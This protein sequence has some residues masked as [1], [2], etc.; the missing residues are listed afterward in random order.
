MRTLGFPKFTVNVY[1]G[2]DEYIH[3]WMMFGFVFAGSNNFARLAK[4]S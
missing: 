1:L 4:Y 3:T 2:K